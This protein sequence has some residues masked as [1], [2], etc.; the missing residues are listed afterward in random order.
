MF[1]QQS[2]SGKIAYLKIDESQFILRNSNYRIDLSDDC[3]EAE[4]TAELQFHAYE[5]TILVASLD[6]DS[7]ELLP[8]HRVHLKKAL[9]K[10]DCV[11]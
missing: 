3:K 10:S 7:F 8:S 1:L 9:T 4:I 2:V 5:N 11:P 6:V